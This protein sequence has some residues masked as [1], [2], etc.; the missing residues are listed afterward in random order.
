MYITEGRVESVRNQCVLLSGLLHLSFPPEVSSFLSSFLFF[1]LSLSFLSPFLSSFLVF[2]F[3]FLFFDCLIFNFFILFY[4]IL[5]YFILFYFI[6]FL[7]FISN[8][9]WTILRKGIGKALFEEML[10]VSL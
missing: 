1:L 9:F 4:F 2:C 8:K 10:L 7:F 6:L 3:L 5:F